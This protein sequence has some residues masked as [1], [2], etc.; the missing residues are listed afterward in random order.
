MSLTRVGYEVPVDRVAG[1]SVTR[2]M[3]T[4]VRIAL[5]LAFVTGVA[6]ADDELSEHTATVVGDA[7]DTIGVN[8]QFDDKAG[9]SMTVRAKPG[10]AEKTSALALPTGHGHYNVFV[11]PGRR[12]I[13][14]VETVVSDRAVD[15]KA[16][17]AWVYSPDG[18]LTRTWSY[19]DVLSKKELSA[20]SPTTSHL[21]FWDDVKAT[22]KGLELVVKSSGRRVVLAS[23]ASTFR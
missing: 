22:A 12:A 3:T 10:A 5:A 17:L 19:A 11:T 15:P 16:T 21:W 23:D 9:W 18:K 4:F 2:E 1:P 14:F 6:H 8:V 7:K 13:A 20:G